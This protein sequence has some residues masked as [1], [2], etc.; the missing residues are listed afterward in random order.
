MLLVQHHYTDYGVCDI[1]FFVTMKVTII[2]AKIFRNH[3]TAT[4]T[5]LC[6][7]LEFVRLVEHLY[8]FVQTVEKESTKKICKCFMVDRQAFVQFS[9]FTIHL[10]ASYHCR[11]VNLKMNWLCGFTFM[12]IHFDT[13]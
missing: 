2:T 12:C 1:S 11:E 9:F 10:T 13:P 8:Y 4:T 7:Y 6:L 3:S 5:T